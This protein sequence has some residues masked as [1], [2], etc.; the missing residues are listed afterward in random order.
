MAGGATGRLR[1]GMGVEKDRIEKEPQG[2]RDTHF[3]NSVL[4]KIPRVS[5]LV[6]SVAKDVWGRPC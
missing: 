3:S 1:A 2:S 4:C 6:G 5:S